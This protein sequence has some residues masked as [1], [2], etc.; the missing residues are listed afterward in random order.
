[1]GYYKYNVF[2]IPNTSYTMLSAGVEPYLYLDGLILGAGSG[3]FY[4][5][6][7]QE[8]LNIQVSEG[9]SFTGSSF[10]ISS[11]FE[12]DE[13]LELNF[14]VRWH[15]FYRGN[16]IDKSLDDYVVVARFIVWF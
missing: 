13:S 2:D 1:I 10:W 16:E 15:H 7:Q 6:M 11:G 5:V 4:S 14:R 8:F 9:E 3:I 12:L